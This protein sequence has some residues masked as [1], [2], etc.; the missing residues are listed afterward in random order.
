[1]QQT[2]VGWDIVRFTDANWI[3]WGSG[4][5]A[6]AKVLGTADGFVVVRVEA[7]PGYTSEPH[8]HLFPEFLYVIDGTVRNQGRPMEAGDGYAAA[9]GTHHDDFTTQTGATYLTIFKV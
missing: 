1:M 4:E 2:L 3:P 9:A 5:Q 8:P 7:R 6:R